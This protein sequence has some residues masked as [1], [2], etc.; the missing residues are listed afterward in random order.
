[1]TLVKSSGFKSIAI[2]CS[3]KA[4]P[5]RLA[6]YAVDA[7]FF[8]VSEVVSLFQSRYNWSRKKHNSYDSLS[9]LHESPEDE[10]GEIA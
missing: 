8:L 5:F 6:Q 7:S 9:H 1:M 4:E 10:E 3:V 2:S